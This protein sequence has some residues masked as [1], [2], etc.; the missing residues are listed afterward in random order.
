MQLRAQS[1]ATTSIYCQTEYSQPISAAN[2][3]D[4]LGNSGGFDSA[5]EVFMTMHYINLLLTLTFDID[6]ISLKRVCDF[7]RIIS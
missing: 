1:T 7:V 3:S 2:E 4:W 6:C 5:L